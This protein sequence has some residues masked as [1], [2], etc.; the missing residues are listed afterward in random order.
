MRAGWIL[1]IVFLLLLLAVLKIDVR[2]IGP[3]NSK[4]GLAFLNGPVHDLLG[5][6]KIFYT[7][8][9]ISGT[10][11]LIAA[12][13]FALFGVLQLVQRRSL[14]S[15][16]RDLLLLGGFYVLTILIYLLFE[17]VIINYRPVIL[18]EGLEAS[19]PSTHS[20]LSLMICGTGMMQLDRRLKE[21]AYREIAVDA[22]GII[23]LVTVVC[24]LLSGVHWLTDILAGVALGGALTCFYAGLEERFCGGRGGKKYYTRTPGY[25]TMVLFAAVLTA[26]SPMRAEAAGAYKPD[27]KGPGIGLQT[28]ASAEESAA[29][30][31]TQAAAESQAAEETQA[32]AESQAAE[33]TQAAESQTAAGGRQGKLTLI[34]AGDNLMHKTIIDKA[35]RPEAGAHDFRF[36]YTEIRDLIRSRDLAVINQE[37][38]FISDNALISDY[39]AFGTPQ[40]MGEALVDTG[41]DVVLSATN[42]TWDKGARGV[43]DTLNYWKT[44]HP[45]I[46]LLGIHESPEAFNTIDYLE[47][48]G[49]RLALF[50]YTY[51]LN[52][53][54][55]PG[56]QYYMVNLLSQRDKFLND[57]R[58]AEGQAD[59]T[60][61]FLHIGEEYQYQPTAFQQGWVHSLIDAGADLV[62]CAHPHVVEPAGYVTTAAGN[63]GL[64]FWSCGNFVSAQTKIPRILG[65]LADVTIEKNESGTRV[66]DWSFLPTVSHFCGPD[67]RVFLLKDYPE[68]LAAVHH[69]NGSDA[70]LTTGK[71]WELWKSITGFDR[72]AE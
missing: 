57:V 34:A 17:K 3:E 71:L 22:F 33:E 27:T 39:P 28:E 52:G 9:K 69:V 54:S 68:E 29:A 20:M 5:F 45:E 16:D 2:P 72:M 56:S 40:V 8:S 63:S 44:A 26:A 41:F 4:V 60:V 7:I 12:A 64:V 6:N 24:R 32:A 35:W 21:W 62:I 58:T 36:L 61:C 42:H 11:T 14:L 38:I 18:D 23:M 19:F 37:T 51:G 49:I 67:V 70:P 25:F 65:G 10:L 48:N 30:A 50:N 43:T 13:G 31:E 66:T 1:L 46:R 55:V 15:V 53:F 47:K 59:M